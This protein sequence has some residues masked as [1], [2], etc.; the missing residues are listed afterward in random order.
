M[1]EEN[2]N[3]CILISF[4][5]ARGCC[6]HVFVVNNDGSICE[7][8]S[9]LTEKA[10]RLAHF[11]YCKSNNQLMVVDMQGSGYTLF[12]PEIASKELVY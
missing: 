12:D 10:E 6:V 7:P 5:W 9:E 1:H 4:P 11:S 2:E 8:C 3:I